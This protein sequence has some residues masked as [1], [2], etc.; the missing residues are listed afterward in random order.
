MIR[1]S[2]REPGRDVEIRI[3]GV[4]PGEKL[5]E[6]LFEVGEHV[7]PTHHPKLRRATRPPIEPEWLDERLD[8][9]QALA[10]EGDRLGVEQLLTS[11]IR[12]PRREVRTADL[13][14]DG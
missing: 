3:T 2:G 7:E 1:L 13:G 11:M 6:D 12:S 10:A 8:A 9:L 4:R 14:A 5:H